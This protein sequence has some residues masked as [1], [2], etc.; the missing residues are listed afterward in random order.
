ME[1]PAITNSPAAESVLAL[2]AEVGDVVVV[3]VVACK[4]SGVDVTFPLNS[5]NCADIIT[6]VTP[7]IVGAASEPAAIL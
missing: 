3:V 6:P 1:F 7:V 2:V 4:S 5:A